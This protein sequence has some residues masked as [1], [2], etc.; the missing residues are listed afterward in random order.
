MCFCLFQ[1][2]H[3]SHAGHLIALAVCRLNLTDIRPCT[4]QQ[5]QNTSDHCKL[6]K[7]ALPYPF[8]F[9]PYHSLHNRF[10]LLPT[11][12][13]LSDKSRASRLCSSAKHFR[14]R[15][16]SVGSVCPQSAHGAN[17]LI[18]LASTTLP[19][20]REF[21]IVCRFSKESQS[22]AGT[23]QDQT[24]PFTSAISSSAVP[25]RRIFLSS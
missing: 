5:K 11:L 1:G 25:C 19:R 7:S 24:I 16:S 6:C 12:M 17:G 13:L 3:G 9:I 18:T 10:P 14:Y 22:P 2:F 23:R 8:P 4:K 21:T 20:L 15:S